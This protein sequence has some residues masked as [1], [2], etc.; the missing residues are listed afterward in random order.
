MLASVVFVMNAVSASVVP[1]IAAFSTFAGR[2]A[3]TTPVC[4]ASARGRRG[5]AAA[6]LKN[7]LREIFTRSPIQEIS[8]YFHEAG[9]VFL[10]WIVPEARHDDDARVGQRLFQLLLG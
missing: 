2:R 6:S 10:V 4:A 9:R 3:G 5:A 8:S 7:V 1:L